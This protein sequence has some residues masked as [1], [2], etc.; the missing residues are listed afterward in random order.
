MNTKSIVFG[1]SATAI[2]IAPLFIFNSL[3]LC[4]VGLIVVVSTL[5]TIGY[6]QK[7]KSEMNTLLI[8][9]AAAMREINASGEPEKMRKQL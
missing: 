2:I 4:G 5:N 1:V 6:V 3:A 7:Q 8:K 9:Y